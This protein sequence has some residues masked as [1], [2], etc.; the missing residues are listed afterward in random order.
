MLH[1]TAVRSTKATSYSSPFSWNGDRRDAASITG[2]FHRIPDSS[3]HAKLEM[4]KDGTVGEEIGS[5][6]LLVEKGGECTV[7]QR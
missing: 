7:N 6:E 4:L 5:L 1:G 3:S 2:E